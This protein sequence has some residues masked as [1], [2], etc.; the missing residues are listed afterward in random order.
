M[1][2]RVPKLR[3]LYEYFSNYDREQINDMLSK[4]TEE[5]R[6]LIT[7]RY[8]EDLDNPV[9]DSSWSRE[10]IDKFYGSLIPKMRGLLAKLDINFQKENMNTK[11]TGKTEVVL[12]Q[13]KHSMNRLDVKEA[14][15]DIVNEDDL[16]NKDN[17]T[18]DEYIKI[19]EL[20]KTQMFCHLMEQ[21]SSKAA[22]I[23]SLRFGYINGKYFSTEAISEFLGIEENEVIDVIKNVLLLYKEKLNGF[24]DTVIQENSKV[25]SIRYDKNSL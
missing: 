12:E 18:K 14:S 25:L 6:K 15:S 4:L 22:I 19:L 3:T 9:T 17:I 21:L 2:N 13:E 1:V 23:I 7:L 24:I 16:L 5:E 20:L 11:K 8:G 10:N